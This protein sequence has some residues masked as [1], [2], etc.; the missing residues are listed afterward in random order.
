MK[1]NIYLT[2]LALIISGCERNENFFP[3]E[4]GKILNYHIEFFDGD[5]LKDESKLVYNVINKNK[6]ISEVIGNSGQFIT[7]SHE[8]NGIKRK[9]INYLKFENILNYDGKIKRYRNFESQKLDKESDHFV[10]KYPIIVGTSWDINDLTRLKMKIGYD[11]VYETW[12]PFILTKKITSLNER[13]LIKNKV[14]K[15]CIKVV[16]KGNTSYNAGPPL[17]NINI[18]I[19]TYDWFAP[20]IGLIKTVRLEESDSETMGKIKTIKTFD[21]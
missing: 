21:N 3:L 18:E 4:T 19:T 10:I 15:D 7:Y 12:L 8:D 14:F 17:G 16:G 20:N 2:F 6:G 5:N 11:R 13:V 9:E 1:N